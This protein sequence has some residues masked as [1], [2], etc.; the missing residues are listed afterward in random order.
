MNGISRRPRHPNSSVADRKHTTFVS[1]SMFLYWTTSLKNPIVDS[2]GSSLALVQQLHL[3]PFST[4]PEYQQWLRFV[5]I[6][7]AC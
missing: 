6:V 2:H 5:D 4:N 7:F 1:M 3:D